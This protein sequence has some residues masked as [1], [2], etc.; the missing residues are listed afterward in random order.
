ML[1]DRMQAGEHRWIDSYACM[2]DEAARLGIAADGGA[3]ER[4]GGAV[5]SLIGQAGS[6]S[7]GTEFSDLARLLVLTSQSR[8]LSVTASKCLPSTRASLPGLS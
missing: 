4:G 8:E 5:A 1:L 6:A 2:T 3:D 7:G